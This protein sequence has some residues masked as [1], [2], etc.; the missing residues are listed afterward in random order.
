MKRKVSTN[1]F[2]LSQ[3]SGVGP[4]RTRRLTIGFEVG[5]EENEE[6]G[7]E[8]DEEEEC[9]KWPKKRRQEESHAGHSSALIFTEN[10]MR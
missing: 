7:H 8:D 1:F 9:H 4:P 10:Q 3:S 6:D 5:E 2:F